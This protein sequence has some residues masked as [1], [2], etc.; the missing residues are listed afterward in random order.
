[1]MRMDKP[2]HAIIRRVS[3]SR[4]SASLRTMRHS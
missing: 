3:S 1:V 2:I 4:S